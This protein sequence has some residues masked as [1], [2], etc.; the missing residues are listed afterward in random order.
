MLS[1]Q[2]QRISKTKKFE[3]LILQKC[4]VFMQ[5]QQLKLLQQKTNL[6]MQSKK[7]GL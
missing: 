6:K 2:F 7:M 1:S 5:Q 3:L 4:S